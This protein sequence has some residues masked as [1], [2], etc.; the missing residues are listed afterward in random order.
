M[1]KDEIWEMIRKDKEKV[2]GETMLDMF[3]KT[4]SDL[5]P[6][7]YKELGL[8]QRGLL[9][10]EVR[11]RNAETAE[12]VKRSI[13]E[14]GSNDPQH[15][16]DRKKIALK[17]IAKAGNEEAMDFLMKDLEESDV[18]DRD[19]NSKEDLERVV[20][21]GAAQG[22]NKEL[23]RKYLDKGLELDDSLFYHA[24]A[25]GHTEL[26]SWLCKQ[27]KGR[28]PMVKSLELAVEGGHIDTMK[29]IMDN[30]PDAFSYR[31][32]GL[33]AQVNRPDAAE[34]LLKNANLTPEERKMALDDALLNAAH[35][36]RSKMVEWLLKMG[37][38]NFNKA[39]LHVVQFGT[40][41]HI[42]SAR[43]LIDAGATELEA[44]LYMAR[45]SRRPSGPMR[46]LL[47]KEIEE[48]KGRKLNAP[49]TGDQ[50]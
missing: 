49:G 41:G 5:E 14:M 1:N 24:V 32:V 6:R 28:L 31:L 50:P 39:L 25:Y 46:D 35:W 19:E 47:S 11:L 18:I 30:H 37:A 26:L 9:R 43:M 29:W 17:Y 15:A 12:D 16:F 2:Y 34:C 21:L 33:A 13:R 4:A 42:D 23:I 8:D 27:A 40:E 22:G 20:M 3:L 38:D 44:A 7:H 36:G 45:S 10:P 48:R